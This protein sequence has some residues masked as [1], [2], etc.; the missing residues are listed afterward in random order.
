M[1]DVE[2]LAL[3]ALA[4]GIGLVV[5]LAI[6]L[7][8]AARRGDEQ[9]RPP[10]REVTDLTVP[11]QWEIDAGLER[12]RRFAMGEPTRADLEWDEEMWRPKTR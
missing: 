2:V 3:I 4:C 10:R 9:L 5:S 8:A 1:P 6:G 7:A 11:P 12:L